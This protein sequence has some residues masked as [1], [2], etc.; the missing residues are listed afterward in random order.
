MMQATET[1]SVAAEP[2]AGRAESAEA[3]G[4]SPGSVL[5]LAVERHKY[6]GVLYLPGQSYQMA[7]HRVAANLDAGLIMVPGRHTVDWWGAAGRVLA[8]EP[9]EGEPVHATRRGLGALRI[10]QGV[11]YDPGAAAFRHHSA[12]NET[13]HHASAFVR[14]AHS[15]PHCDLRQYDGDGDLHAVRELVHEADVLHCHINYMLLANT[16]MRPRADQLVIRHYH[17]SRPNGLTWLERDLDEAHHA[18][19]VGARLSHVAEWERI[20][21]LPIPVPVARYA[22]LRHHSGGTALRV[23]H[24]PTKRSYKGTDVF[25]RTVERLQRQH[26][27]VEPVLIEGMPLNDALLLKGT[28]DILF[29]SFWLGIQG[30]GLEAAAMGLPVVAGDADVAA[31]YKQ[32][33]GEVPYTVALDELQLQRQL[34][35]LAVD[36]EYRASEAARAH[37]YVLAVHDYAAVGARYEAMLA[38][39]LKRPEILTPKGEPVI[40][41]EPKPKREPKRPKPAAQ[42]PKPVTTR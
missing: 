13:T 16:G 41:P 11:G 8:A 6:D 39:A 3:R 36:A 26:V 33:V 20:Q 17:G 22:A 29:D 27:P 4:Q 7:A 35:R 21:W 10:V 15:N 37:A 34:E 1:V 14:W 42:K 2:R 28:C 25:L 18:L 38:A 40:R 23:G 32:H 19:V 9:L 5:V 12:V 31:L 24:S 30:S